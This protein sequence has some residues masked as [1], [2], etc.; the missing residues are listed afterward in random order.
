MGCE[1]RYPPH[2]G[3]PQ[4]HFNVN[5]DISGV[6]DPHTR[7][8]G[9]TRTLKALARTGQTL[10]TIGKVAKPVAVVTD[11]VTV[12]VAINQDGGTIGKNTVVAGARV[13]MGWAS[14][15]AGAS[16]GAKGGAA[17]GATIGAF[18]GGVGAAPGAAIG[19]F[20]GGVGGGIAGAF[21]G[22][23]LGEKGAKQLIK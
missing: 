18:F 6:P 4:P 2:P 16:L 8:P 10:N 5:P 19:G 1:G 21:G 15:A 23:W 13:T 14:A 22:S 20:I 11:V 7:I 17:I 9:G 12:G 3:T